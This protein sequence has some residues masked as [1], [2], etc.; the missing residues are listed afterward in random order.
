MSNVAVNYR[1]CHHSRIKDLPM[2]RS[3]IL[4][5]AVLCRNKT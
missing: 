4:T 3:N 2:R 5:T 1:G